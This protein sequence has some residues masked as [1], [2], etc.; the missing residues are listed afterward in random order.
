M[1]ISP[2]GA[3]LCRYLNHGQPRAPPMATDDLGPSSATFPRPCRLRIDTPE[4]MFT[5]R[6]NDINAH[7]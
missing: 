5:I 3:G 7:K 4:H 6:A 2:L 1:M